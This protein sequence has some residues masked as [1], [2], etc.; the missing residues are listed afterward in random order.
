MACSSFSP[1]ANVTVGTFDGSSPAARIP[2]AKA[3]AESPTTLDSTTSGFLSAISR[4]ISS[5]SVLPKA[6]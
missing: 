2:R 4:T 5:T 6:R 1:T 3:I